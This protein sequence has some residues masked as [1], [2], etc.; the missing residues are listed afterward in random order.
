MGSRN[1]APPESPQFPSHSSAMQASESYSPPPTTPFLDGNLGK[2]MKSIARF[3]SIQ[4]QRLSTTKGHEAKV[5]KICKES[6]DNA[7]TDLQQAMKALSSKNVE[8]VNSLLNTVLSDVGAC[9]H[10]YAGKLSPFANYDDTV[11]KMTRSC[12]VVLRLAAPS[13]PT[14]AYTN[15]NDS[16]K[17]S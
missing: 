15:D 12:L 4:A 3:T 2:T 8:R 16:I 17:I 1:A 6:Y 13:T 11:T 5:L 7:S 14:H 9:R 10:E